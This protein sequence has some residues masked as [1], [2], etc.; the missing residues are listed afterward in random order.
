M[1]LMSTV[2]GSLWEEGVPLGCVF[3][4]F[5]K[6][7]DATSGRGFVRLERALGC[8]GSRGLQC[9]SLGLTEIPPG[10]PT[11]CAASGRG[12]EP[13]PEI[14]D[15]LPGQ[16]STPSQHLPVTPVGPS[17]PHCREGCVIWALLSLWGDPTHVLRVGREVG[18][19]RGVEQVI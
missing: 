18:L 17:G 7:E 5:G 10:L 1:N 3:P 19:L 15:S 4:R 14:R 12:K 8:G 2:T 16:G 13:N 9:Q 11:V 6:G